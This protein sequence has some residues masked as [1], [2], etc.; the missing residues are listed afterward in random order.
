MRI[1]RYSVW[2]VFAICVFFLFP[3]RG[4]AMKRALVIGNS[5]YQDAP[6]Q[7]PV[8]DANDMTAMLELVGF[9]VTTY[10]NNTQQG[11][12][13]AIRTFGNQLQT[14][15][16]A[17]FYFSGHG[18]QVNGVNYLLPINIRVYDEE[19]IKYQAVDV[20]MLLDKLQRARTQINIII[21]D[22][23]R[24]NPFKGF[25][26]YSRGLAHMS[27]P[28]GTI[29]AYAT[30]PGTVAYDDRQERN[31]PYTRHLLQNMIR[32]GL[33]LEEV[34]K[35]TRI[36][37]MKETKNKQ[38]P[39]E[40]SSLTGD[41]YFVPTASPTPTP[42]PTAM[43]RPLPTVMPTSTPLQPKCCTLQVVS[44][45]TGASIFLNGTYYGKTPLSY[46][47]LEEGSVYMVTIEKE[48]Y[49]RIE[50]T[51]EMSTDL[52][53]GYDLVAKPTPVPPIPSPHPP[54]PIRSSPNISS[55]AKGWLGVV[56]RDLSRLTTQQAQ[57]VGLLDGVI[58]DEI[59]PGGAAERAGLVSGDILITFNKRILKNVN[60]VKELVA[61][62]GSGT[63][64][65][66]TILRHGQEQ[67]VNV[68][69]GSRKTTSSH[70]EEG[71][72]GVVI[73]DISLEEAKVA[74][75]IPSDGVLIEEVLHESPAEKGGMLR[76]D[77]LVQFDKQILKN[78]HTVKEL[79]AQKAPGTK[80]NVM[81][82]RNRKT[83]QL[84][85]TLEGEPE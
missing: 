76:G 46:K 82:I 8:S 9:H 24:N 22:A 39:W 79:V 29:I 37:V 4:N 66:V 71:W 20:R 13:H 18:V 53:R 33:K 14:G 30:A 69:L 85:I 35:N 44:H 50:E 42:F 38:V 7:N 68:I 63:S 31:S 72:L 6:L 47:N 25:R 49:E 5:Q 61:Q 45:P 15:D 84:R 41:F 34:F 26:S 16:I 55:S 62:R 81:I 51:L 43:P 23:C 57:T 80:I 59:I 21:L 56:I 83:Q 1:N 40:S 48:G 36:A 65:N 78:V 27:A 74:G 58:I 54:I 73:Q 70:R 12:E 32:N 17:L 2:G 64:V 11:M 19:E 10:L 3:I 28:T 77:I 75:L 52:F 67:S 60:V